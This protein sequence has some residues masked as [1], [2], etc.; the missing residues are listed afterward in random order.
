MIFPLKYSREKGIPTRE[1]RR[2][3]F[4]QWKS[5]HKFSRTGIS[6]KQDL[7]ANNNGMINK[8]EMHWIS[9]YKDNH[10]AP[11]N[12]QC[13]TFAVLLYVWLER[14]THKYNNSC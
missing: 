3:K 6:G 2:T 14:N 8:C 12:G 9:P 10:I 13:T 5:K 1:K 11:N 4:Y 7:I